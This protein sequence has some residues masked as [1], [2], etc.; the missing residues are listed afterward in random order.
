MPPILLFK[1]EFLAD[2]ADCRALFRHCL[3]PAGVHSDAGVEAACLQMYKSWESLV[4]DCT[5]SYLCGRLR[6]DGKLVRCD[7]L[8]R[9]EE[10]A[11][12]LL[13]QDKP[14]VEWTDIDRVV[15][16]WGR[17]FSPSN[18][19]ETAVRGA[20]A[21]LRQLTVVRNAIAHASPAASKKFNKLIRD[22]FGGARHMKRPATFLKEQFPPDPTKTFFD[23]YADVLE[24]AGLQL[25]G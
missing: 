16:R 23:R 11:R 9:S 22:Q 3:H 13:Y 15:E 8:I 2:I 6:C 17:M 1:R 4:E 14:F 5:V 19:L 25:T 10:L 21:E 20:K 24:T 7:A 18:L 12:A